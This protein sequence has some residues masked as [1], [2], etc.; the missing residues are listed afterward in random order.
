MAST[1]F[2]ARKKFNSQQFKHR[3]T[4]REREKK[5]KKKT[6]DKERY[7]TQTRDWKVV[8]QVFGRCVRRPGLEWARVGIGFV[9]KRSRHCYSV[10]QVTKR[11]SAESFSRQTLHRKLSGPRV[12]YVLLC[13]I[14]LGIQSKPI[15]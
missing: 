4:E 6:R 10:S 14:P 1:L 7:K 2:S 9:N 5:K 8:K 12:A 13:L 11:S 15:W 3:K